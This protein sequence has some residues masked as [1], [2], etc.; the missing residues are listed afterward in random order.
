[1]A[2]K[3]RRNLTVGSTEVLPIPAGT[4]APG[5]I[6]CGSG[7]GPPATGHQVRDGTPPATTT[8]QRLPAS[9]G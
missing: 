6:V 3:I 4:Q 8:V 1:M 2:G 7:G 5:G 9:D